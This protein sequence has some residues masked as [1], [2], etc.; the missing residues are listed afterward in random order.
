MNMDS[1]ELPDFS[2]WQSVNKD[3]TF[4]DYIYSS[5]KL[6]DLPPDFMLACLKLFW[7]DFF[8]ENGCVFLKENFKR[9][10]YNR[11]VEQ[12][13]SQRELEYWM[14]LLSL[15]GFFSNGRS[16][17]F[18]SFSISKYLGKQLIPIWTSKLHLDFPKY[19]FMV[20]CVVDESEKEVFMVL[21]QM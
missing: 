13:L 1:P 10:K 6:K 8:V 14:N 3:F 16:N 5:I 9:E 17:E 12:G 11:L 20:K 4:F 21:K 15:D 2:K 19:V 18:E 7:P